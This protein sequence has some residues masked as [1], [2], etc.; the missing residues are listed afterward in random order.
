MI[1]PRSFG[2]IISRKDTRVYIKAFTFWVARCIIG[3]VKLDVAIAQLSIVDG[4]WQ[5]SPDSVAQFDES[6]LFGITPGRG[7]LYIVAE[8]TGE[9]EGRD[10]LARELI[11]TTRREYAASHGSIMLGLT[12]AVRA[13]NEAIY[14][15]NANSPQ[16]ARRIAGITAAI[17]RDDELFI[18]QAGPGLT[19][20]VRGATLQ[21]YPEASPWFDPNEE[22]LGEMMQSRSFPT[23]GAVPLGMRSAYTPDQ[24]HVTLQAADTIVL[25]TRSL[26]HLLS[27]EEVLDTLAHRHPDEII[28]NLEDLAGAA[29]L[30]V[31]AL[32]VT[33]QG[34]PQ[35]A[36]E[37]PSSLPA[38][39][40]PMPQPPVEEF[41]PPISHAASTLEKQSPAAGIPADDIPSSVAQQPE[42]DGMP[43]PLEETL[44]EPKPT[45][46]RQPIHV[47]LAPLRTGVLRV[48]SG[49]MAFLA[50]SFARVNW[51]NVSASADR[52]ISNV[53]RAF[54]RATLFL[55]R[56]VLPG[57]PKEDVSASTKPPPREAGWRLL[58]LLFPVVLIAAGGWMWFNA[59][60]EQQRAQGAEVAQLLA[61]AK[62]QVNTG[63][64]LAPVNKDG[65]RDAFQTA[66]TLTN[67]AKA[68]NPA[69]ATI[70]SVFYSAQ[71]ELDKLN[72]I[73]VLL[74]L[75]S[76]ATYPDAAAQPARI[77]MRYPDIYLLDRGTSRL[78]HYIVNDAGPSVT[79]TP[80]DG[81]ILKAGDKA[82]DRSGSERSVGDLI[83]VTWV[84][85]G[86]RLIVIDRAG[87]FLEYDPSKAKWNAFPAR[88]GDKWSRVTL[89][90]NY[91]GNLYLVDQGRNQILKYVAAEG[92]W[93]S[94]VTYFAPGV[95]VDLSGVTDL[96]IDGDV[97]L[98]RADGSIARFTQ[99]KPNDL[100]IRDL[101]TPLSKSVAVVTSEKSNNAYVADAGNQRIVQIDKVSGKFLRQFKPRGQDRDTFNSLKTLA[102]DE[103]N[104]KFFFVNGNQVYLATIPQ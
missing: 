91:A 104:K 53:S 48:T 46:E 75:P 65:A 12:Q 40:P 26:T 16:E 31:I 97:W 84:E 102:V 58:A 15:F 95:N 71:D 50:A 34:V 28:T 81:I 88:D 35:P 42:A 101:D 78:Y 62:T 5:E 30:S 89:V 10:V 77:V 52:S 20:L 82:T 96:A 22:A 49:A 69:D 79:P 54:A 1:R 47:D 3:T 21:R 85:P 11:E 72:G 99:G 25:A 76:F 37:S 2:G 57:E 43:A 93:T 45:S 56:S 90:S 39:L 92:A 27:N 68:I 44:A 63:K 33:G 61:Q 8:V 74:F 29:D 51:R 86:G 87:T 66:I 70:T 14:N 7:S 103:Q 83:D 73:S 23:D 19:C 32:Q 24:F 80:G 41:L 67:Q 59:K 60:A 38:V 100:P 94:S 36:G 9:P 98:S 17:Q 13:A 4:A 55:L 64:G 6:A 18:A